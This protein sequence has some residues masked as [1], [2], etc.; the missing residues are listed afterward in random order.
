MKNK[1]FTLIELVAVIVIMGMILLIVFPATSR[2]MRDNE[3]KE[4]QTFY[5]LTTE[6]LEQYARTRRDDIG[7][8]NGSGCIDT[9]TQGFGIKN[10]IENDYLK[11]FDMDDETRNSG[12]K[13]KEIS[14]YEGVICRTPQEFSNAELSEAGIDTS[15]QYVGMRIENKEGKIS[16]NLSMVCK[17]KGSRKV[18]YQNLIEKTEECNRYVA[19]IQSSLVKTLMDKKAAGS[20]A[21][22]DGG[23]ND[24]YVEGSSNNNYVWYSGKLWRIVSYNTVEKTVK[25]VTDE[26]ISLITYNLSNPNASLITNDYRNSN[27]NLW[28]N[29]IFL[30]TLKN[31]EKYLN[32]YAW[33][34]TTNTTNVPVKPTIGS[35]VTA[36]VGM[37]NYYEYYKIGGFLNIGKMYWLLT[38]SNE[39]NQ[40]WYVDKS[41]QGKKGDVTSFI[42]VRPSIVL[43]PNVTI[44]NGGDGTVNNPYIL[45][46]DTSASAGTYLNTR[47]AG[48]YVKFNNTNFR[49][50]ETSPEYT[51]LISVDSVK[52][53]SEFHYF[54]RLY[55]NNTTI[56]SFLLSWVDTNNNML[57]EADFCRRQMTNQT[58]QTTACPVSDKFNTTI[59][60][61]VL[62]EMFTTNSSSEYWTM[63]NDLDEVLDPDTGET[64][65]KIYVIEPD[66]T[67]SSKQI[68]QLSGI[69]AVVAIKNSAMISAGNGTSNS[70]YEIQ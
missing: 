10:L 17:K 41:N 28:L 55:S 60:I 39:S 32:D 27:I 63:N 18:E 3:D 47:Y 4:Y 70:P 1:G 19:D 51:K 37:L 7:G 56:G 15:K 43:K 40:V 31:P 58:S 68:E 46:G 54:D 11:E 52:E 59:A 20:F 22:T 23:D 24:F 57:V 65:A 44:L 30:K 5:D 26:N 64:A 45:N 67:I 38:K 48:E 69:K 25:L 34:Y 53:N 13:A 61:P 42:G 9:V 2:L 16:V 35:T 29:N 6:A 21:V 12:K 66:G 49:I 33:N 50:L 14:D 8:S 36:K 62:G